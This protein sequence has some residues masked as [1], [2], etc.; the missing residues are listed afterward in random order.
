M[1]VAH[2]T[3]CEEQRFIDHGYRSLAGIDE[4]GRGAWAG[5]V[6]AAAVVLPTDEPA[7]L[8]RLR[9]VRDS[10]LCT[11]HQRDEL[12]DLLRDA[13]L[14]WAVSL[15]PALRIDQVG[16]V[17]ATRE[18]MQGAV[19]QLDPSPD[20]LLIDALPLPSLPIPQRVLIKGDVRC[21]S[22]AAASILAKVTRDRAMLL[23]DEEYPGY[24]FCAHKGYGTPEHRAALDWLGPTDAHRWYFT[25]V[26]EVV[27]RQEIES[28]RPVYRKD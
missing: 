20:A 24:G 7:L 18:A 5:P 10:K 8:H 2:P 11:P 23:M 19:A 17:S 26:A 12:Y 25:P 9:G 16:I 27:R 15:V 28:E 13:A 3:L 4:A 14:R 22:I 21:L 1:I 6:A